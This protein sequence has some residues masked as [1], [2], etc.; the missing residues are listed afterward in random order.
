MATRPPTYRPPGYKPRHQAER[1]RKA[2][3]DLQRPPST[4]RGYD[5]AWRKVRRQFLERHPICCECSAPATDADHVRS[6]RERPDLR[7][8]WSNLRPYCHRHHSARTA[9]DQ[10]FAKRSHGAMHT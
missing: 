1:E 8:S 9:R 3:L 7:L 6:V 10:G 5:A 2:K 4:D